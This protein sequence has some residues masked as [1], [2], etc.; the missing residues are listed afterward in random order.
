MMILNRM[1][2]IGYIKKV[3]VNETLERECLVHPRD[4]GNKVG[5]ER[6][7]YALL[8]DVGNSGERK[9]TARAKSETGMLGTSE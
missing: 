9:D 3:T 5:I 8:M 6:Y 7:T 1:S 2:S 4:K